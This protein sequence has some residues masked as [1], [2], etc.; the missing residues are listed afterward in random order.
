MSRVGHSMLAK[1]F[2]VE[3]VAPNPLDNV[4][5]AKNCAPRQTV[6]AC[7]CHLQTESLRGSGQAGVWAL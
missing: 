2:R 1:A 5:V 4:A 3:S 7:R 6:I